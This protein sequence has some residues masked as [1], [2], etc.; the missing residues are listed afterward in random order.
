[1]WIVTSS[2]QNRTSLVNFWNSIIGNDQLIVTI[3]LKNIVP[4]QISEQCAKLSVSLRWTK[5][6]R[7]Y[8]ILK[9]HAA[10]IRAKLVTPCDE[11]ALHDMS[12]GVA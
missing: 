2:N 11:E 7:K 1:M 6:V 12:P 10:I 3:T 5:N 9:I 4:D 8:A